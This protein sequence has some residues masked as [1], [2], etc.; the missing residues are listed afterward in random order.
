MTARETAVAAVLAEHIWRGAGPVAGDCQCGWAAL[1]HRSDKRPAEQHHAHVA[2][3]I[4]AALAQPTNTPGAHPCCTHC[5]TS[6]SGHHERACDTCRPD[7]T[8]E[9]RAI[10]D[11]GHDRARGAM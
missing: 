6:C 9:L 8:P 3:A 5:G 2:A 4:V 7:V 1:W 10:A 11:E